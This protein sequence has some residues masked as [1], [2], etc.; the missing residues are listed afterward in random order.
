ME[1]NISF[2]SKLNLNNIILR[3]QCILSSYALDNL[4]QIIH[5]QKGFV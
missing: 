5:G 2:G 1:S 4:V 3:N